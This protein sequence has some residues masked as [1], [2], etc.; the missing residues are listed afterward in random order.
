MFFLEA[1]TLERKYLCLGECDEGTWT[2]PQQY[3]YL[4]APLFSQN[5]LFMESTISISVS[6]LGH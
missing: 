5:A 3:S 4:T 2:R 6:K 1:E